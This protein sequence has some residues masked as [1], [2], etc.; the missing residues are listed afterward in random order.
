MGVFRPAFADRGL[1]AVN[2]AS[3]GAVR[4]GGD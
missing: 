1:R 2:D 3:R 4:A